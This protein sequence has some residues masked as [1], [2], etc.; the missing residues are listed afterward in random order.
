MTFRVTDGD[1]FEY[2]AGQWVE[3]E[4]PVA[5]GSVKRPYSIASAPGEAG[6]GQLEVA[7]TH[8][9]G[10]P[11]STALLALAVGTALEL[12]GPSGLF[13]RD[14][15]H[16]S[17]P[18]LF[19]CTGTGVA[20]LRAMLHDE[21]QRAPEGPPIVLL[22]GC[23]TQDDLLFRE[24]FAELAR[25]HRRFRYEPTLSRPDEGWTG[26]RGHVQ[27]HL[28]ELVE[29]LSNAHLYVCGLNKMI[30]EVRALLKGPLGFDRRQVHSERYD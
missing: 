17:L 28:P 29:G 13:T 27:S 26:R 14:H 15:A 6:P 9:G 18:T 19:V 16:D 30:T 5:G 3:L 12:V 4:V 11:A 24:E 2:I 8:V 22:F 21:L 23:R 10:G 1:P 7:V 20:P 25:R